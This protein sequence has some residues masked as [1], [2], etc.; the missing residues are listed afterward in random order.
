MSAAFV[1]IGRRAAGE[2][3]QRVQTL[4]SFLMHSTV[5]P[6]IPVPPWPCDPCAGAWVWKNGLADA[7]I[8]HGAS[9]RIASEA[10]ILPSRDAARL[11][12]AV[13]TSFL[14]EEGGKRLLLRV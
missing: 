6:I 3:E 7:L 5:V 12:L 4:P 2:N 11:M 9:D 14:C 1:H 8:E 13:L 10:R